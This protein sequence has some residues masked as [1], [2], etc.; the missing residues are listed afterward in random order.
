MSTETDASRPHRTR[1][2]GAV[3]G[4]LSE[5]VSCGRLRCASGSQQ[6]AIRNPFLHRAPSPAPG[7]TLPSIADLVDRGAI[8]LVCDFAMGHLSKRLATRAGRGANDVHAD[9]RGVRQQ[10]IRYVDRIITGLRAVRRSGQGNRRGGAARY[11]AAIFKRWRRRR[12]HIVE[13]SRRRD[14]VGIDQT[15]VRRS[16][17][18]AY[19]LPRVFPSGRTHRRPDWRQRASDRVRVSS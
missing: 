1:D 16:V 2:R 10:P 12:R 7:I 14:H 3:P 8:I 5:R 6:P 17:R 19:R 13:P 15:L 11:G 18:G 4:Q 9:L